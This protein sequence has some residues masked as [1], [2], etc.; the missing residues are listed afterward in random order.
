[1]ETTKKKVLIIEDET[2]LLEALTDK[3][4]QAGHT[5][6]QA[7]NGEDGLDTALKHKPDLILLD[8]LLPKKNG[9][10]VLE[11]LRQNAWGKTV[12]VIMLTNVDDWE[13]TKKAVTYDVR[14]Y[15]VK[16]DWKISDVIKIINKKL[17]Q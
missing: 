15:L 3:I 14:D 16:S 2:P 13:N 8:I 5:V 12:K 4:E 1:M 10:E 6:L 11:E 7:K 9:L 17:S